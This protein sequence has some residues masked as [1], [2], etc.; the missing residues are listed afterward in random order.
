[1]TDMEALLGVYYESKKQSE[2]TTDI[3]DTFE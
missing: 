3:Y 1:M 2:R